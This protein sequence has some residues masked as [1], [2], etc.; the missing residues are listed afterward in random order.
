M[1]VFRRALLVVCIFAGI[2]V[3]ISIL[4][5]YDF[6]SNGHAGLIIK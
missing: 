1:I 5:G 6:V 3:R 2:G 4:V